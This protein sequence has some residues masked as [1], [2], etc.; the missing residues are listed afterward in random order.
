[1]NNFIRLFVQE[2]FGSREYIIHDDNPLYAT[3]FSIAEEA[4]HMEDTEI[5]S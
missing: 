5:T 3:L 4:E 2:R 1:M